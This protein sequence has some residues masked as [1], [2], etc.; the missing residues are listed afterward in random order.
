MNKASVLIID[1][2]VQIRKML[3]IT[4]EANDYAVSEATTAKE[5]KAL[6]ASHPPDV[7]LLDL[8]LPD[9]NGHD[10]FKTFARVV[11]QSHHHTFSTKQ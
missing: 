11:H 1:D 6:V 3:T 5:G 4:L 8:G 10:V 7:V 9:E 2:E